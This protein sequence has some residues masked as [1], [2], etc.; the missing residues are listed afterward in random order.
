[1]FEL[2]R[3][4][5]IENQ[6]KDIPGPIRH[7]KKQNKVAF[8]TSMK[9]SFKKA[10]KIIKIE[11]YDAQTVDDDHNHCEPEIS[12]QYVAQSIFDNVYCDIRKVLKDIQDAM[13]Q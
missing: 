2:S 12:A 5:E 13:Y 11:I 10:S 8:Y 9:K 4:P 1:M 7:T 3:S 6:S